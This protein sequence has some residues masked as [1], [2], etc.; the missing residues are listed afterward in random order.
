MFW[1]NITKY[2]ADEL[3]KIQLE[4]ARIVSG[5]NELVSHDNL[6]R[7]TSWGNSNSRRRQHKITLYY[8]MINYLTP[9]YPSSLPPPSLVGEISRYLLRNS[10]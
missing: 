5:T 9:P 10:D 6:Y 2:E 4:A 1:Y 7:D 3:E 8:K